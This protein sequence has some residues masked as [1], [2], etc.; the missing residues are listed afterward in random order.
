MDT[1][2]LP[3]GQHYECVRLGS[4]QTLSVSTASTINRG[5]ENSTSGTG[6]LTTWLE[7]LRS[8]SLSSHVGQAVG[9]ASS[10]VHVPKQALQRQGR[11]QGT[12]KKR[13]RKLLG[14]ERC[15]CCGTLW[16]RKKRKIVLSHF[17]THANSVERCVWKEERSV[18]GNAFFFSLIF[19]LAPRML[20]QQQRS[21]SHFHLFLSLRA[22]AV[23]FLGLNKEN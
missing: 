7:S 13:C 22:A 23:A 4:H 14:L 1:N 19:F 5:N 2:S 15:A 11:H 16:T 6:W 10:L 17:P 8:L 9:S 21:P 12:R 3:S 20:G 18:R